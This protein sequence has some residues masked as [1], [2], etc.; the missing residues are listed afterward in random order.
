MSPTAPDLSEYAAALEP[1]LDPA[2]RAQ[3]TRLRHPDLAAHVGEM[4][5]ALYHPEGPS[6]DRNPC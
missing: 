1:L 2:T 5:A 3:I 4:F 6:H